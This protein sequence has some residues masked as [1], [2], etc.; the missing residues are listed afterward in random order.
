MD[1]NTMKVNLIM[2]KSK[3]LALSTSQMETSL[4]D[5][6]RLIRFKDSAHSI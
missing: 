4:V 2:T 1:G 5:V 3:A 6:L